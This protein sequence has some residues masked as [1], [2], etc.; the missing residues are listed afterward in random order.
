MMLSALEKA[1][2]SDMEEIVSLFQ[3]AVDRLNETGI[4][5]WDEVYPHADDI[6][7]DIRDG[8][9][10]IARINGRITGVITLNQFA[11]PAYANGNWA[12]RGP[13]FMVV[14]R[15]CVAADAQGQGVGTQIM[16]LAETMLRQKGVRSMRLDTFSQNPYSCGMYEK[17]GFHTVGEA[18]F[19]KGLFY[20]MEKDITKDD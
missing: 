4:P 16:K 3:G 7:Q 13:D 12:Y 17:L 19:R 5:Q 11:D 1:A 14:H 10:Y 8:Q 6:A 20:L 2:A 15:L 18:L 9:L